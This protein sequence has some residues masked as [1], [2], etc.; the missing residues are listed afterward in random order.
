MFKTLCMLHLRDSRSE[1]DA[2][3]I[4]VLND[5]NTPLTW[6]QLQRILGEPLRQEMVSAVTRKGRLSADQIAVAEEAVEFLR[7]RGQIYCTG[8]HESIYHLVWSRGHGPE[9]Y[10]RPPEGLYRGQADYR[11]RHESTL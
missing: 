10:I 5:P 9:T 2:P 1:E 8:V 7:A 11:W 4:N 3:L 6:R